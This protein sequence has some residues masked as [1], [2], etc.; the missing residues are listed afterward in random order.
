[1]SAAFSFYSKFI[2]VFLQD[3]KNLQ[4]L[5]NS[6]LVRLDLARVYRKL[7]SVPNEN[8]EDELLKLAVTTLKDSMEFLKVI[9][10]NFFKIAF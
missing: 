2:L 3:G 8:T 9:V 4:A 6:A 7:S 5:Y 1:M 10:G